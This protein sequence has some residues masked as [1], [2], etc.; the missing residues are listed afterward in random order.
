MLAEVKHYCIVALHCMKMSVQRTLEYRIEVIGWLFANPIQV[1]LGIAIIKYVISDFGTI[2]GWGFNEIAFLYGL[3]VISHALSVVFFVQT[4]WMG[5]IMLEGEFDRYMLRPLNVLFQFFFSDFNLIGITDMIPGVITFVYG[6]VMINFKFTTFNTIMLVTVIIGAT[7]IRGALFLVTGSLA[8]W[9]KS[10]NSFVKMNLTVLDQVTKYPLTMYPRIVQ[11][12]FTFL[13]PL[14]FVS[15]YPASD[16]LDKANGFSFPAG[17]GFFT[18]IIG[19]LVFWLSTRMF[20]RGL[21]RY[22]SAGS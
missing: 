2:N 1:F 5:Y 22:E 17:I 11:I 18:L 12:L 10:R 4:W 8:F 7:L 14:G 21:R 9:T 19:L 20:R 6:C 15:F 16:L 13:M 3:A